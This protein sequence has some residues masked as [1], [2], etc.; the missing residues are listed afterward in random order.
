M[1]HQ[2]HPEQS[3]RAETSQASDLTSTFHERLAL[4]SCSEAKQTLSFPWKTHKLEPR[5]LLMWSYYCTSAQSHSPGSG[6][7][8]TVP[9]SESLIDPGQTQHLHWESSCDCKSFRCFHKR[10]CLLSVV[11]EMGTNISAYPQSQRKD[12]LFTEIIVLSMLTS[13]SSREMLCICKF[14]HKM[15][16]IAPLALSL[17]RYPS[18]LQIPAVFTAEARQH[19]VCQSAAHIPE[20]WVLVALK[21][22]VI[23]KCGSKYW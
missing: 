3:T 14:I 9:P 11:P 2:V 16:Q 21:K 13:P 10:V 1:S 23:V 19:H 15:V 8:G 20:Q 18:D 5:L 7:F 6:R 12:W 17:P 22:D 4:C